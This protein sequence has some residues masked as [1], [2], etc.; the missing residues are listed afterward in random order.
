MKTTQLDFNRLGLLFRRFFTENSHKELLQWII[1]IIVFMFVRNIVF[2]VMAVIFV[3][4]AIDAA[5]FSKEIHSRSNGAA[6]FM[7]PATQ[8]EKLIVGVVITS[9]YCFAEMMITYIIGNLLGTFMNNMLTSANLFVFNIFHYSPLQWTLFT[10]TATIW[11]NGQPA[12]Y[13]YGLFQIFIAFL[14]SQS[15]F[16]LGGIYFKRNQFFATFLTFIVIVLL[17]SILL[18]TETRLIF[19]TITDEYGIKVNVNVLPNPTWWIYIK[20]IFGYLLIPFF[21]VVSY[22]RLTE[23]QV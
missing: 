17:L 7:I 6:F 16:F 2:L 23:K 14:F 13:Y 15:M 18:A 20:Q 21:W 10:N 11:N 4:G 9:F 1:M 3:S 12:V 5:R 19:G 8:L 22:F